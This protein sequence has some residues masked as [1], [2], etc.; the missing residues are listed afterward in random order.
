MAGPFGLRLVTVTV[1]EKV[2]YT[3]ETQTT[4]V[5][6]SDEEGN[7]AKAASGDFLFLGLILTVIWFIWHLLSPNEYSKV[8]KS[9]RIKDI[10]SMTKEEYINM[11]N[12]GTDISKFHLGKEWEKE[13]K[14]K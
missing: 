13:K 3:K 5:G 4:N 6:D 2:Y 8:S 7:D 11:Y 9:E 12:V 1:P 14:I 10:P